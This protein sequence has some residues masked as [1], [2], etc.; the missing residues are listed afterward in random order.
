MSGTAHARLYCRDLLF[1]E[2]NAGLK[3]FDHF[4]G[5]ECLFSGAP[6]GI[7]KRSNRMQSQGDLNT[8]PKE[9]RTYWIIGYSEIYNLYYM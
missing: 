7:I 3:A 6:V 9:L 5:V 2:T 1:E 4:T 8:Y